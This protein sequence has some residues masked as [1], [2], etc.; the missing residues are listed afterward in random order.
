[1]FRQDLSANKCFAFTHIDEPIGQDFSF[2]LR[3]D[4]DERRVVIVT[5]GISL[6]PIKF[7]T[8]IQ[9]ATAFEQSETF[10]ANFHYNQKTSIKTWLFRGH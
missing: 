1:M 4:Y 9:V 10:R 3:V 7:G 8:F 2:E 5:E 6:K